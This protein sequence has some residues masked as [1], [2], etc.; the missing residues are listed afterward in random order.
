ME[1]SSVFETA[2]A[3]QRAEN[4]QRVYALL[5]QLDIPYSRVDHDTAHTMADCAVIG[6]KLGV[7]IC[8]NLL[9]TTRNHSVYYL[10]CMP[11]D[12]PFVTREFSK[13]MGCSRL[14]FASEEDLLQLLD[15]TPGSASL[16]ALMNDPG[17]RV[18]L[19]LD[20]SV[21]Q[22]LWFGCHPCRNTSSLRLR[23]EDI[24]HKFLPHTG[25]E[26]VLVDL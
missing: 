8:K 20:R 24:L 19:V 2:P 7:E 14:S 17:H 26:P 25:H 15:V 11:G 23:T 18:Q 6:E 10:L 9:L 5:K 13:L 16:L 4:E 21:A 3:D 1:L 12:K 22:A